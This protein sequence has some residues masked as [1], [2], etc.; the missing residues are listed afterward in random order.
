ME[1][2]RTSPK[3]FDGDRSLMKASM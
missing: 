2:L 3:K 1:H